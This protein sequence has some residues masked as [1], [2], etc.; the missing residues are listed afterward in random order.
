M[1]LVDLSVEER[2]FAP[3]S[4][5]LAIRTIGACPAARN[6]PDARIFC[7]IG[8]LTVTPDHDGYRF[9]TEARCL[10]EGTP[11]SICSTGWSRT[12]HRPMP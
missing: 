3:T 1:S 12:S 8:M 5:A 6:R 11:S 2:G 9:S 4:I 10:G 7:G